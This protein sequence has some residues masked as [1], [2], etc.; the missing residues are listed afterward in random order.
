MAKWPNGSWLDSQGGDW[1]L[2]IADLRKR[3]KQRFSCGSGFQPRFYDCNGL[4]DFSDFNGLNDL[5]FA[6]D[7]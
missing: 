6:A 5:P 4:N 2:R 7:T 1:G 3:R